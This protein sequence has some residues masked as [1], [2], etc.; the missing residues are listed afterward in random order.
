MLTF[1]V[2]DFDCELTLYCVL[3]VT[4]KVANDN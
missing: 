4:H 3:S 2:E 1:V